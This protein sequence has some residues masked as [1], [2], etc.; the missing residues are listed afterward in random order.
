VAALGR[1]N[2]VSKTGF[3]SKKKG[4]TQE[5]RAGNV[6]APLQKPALSV[7]VATAEEKIRES[8]FAS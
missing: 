8:D 2:V 3:L 4:V 7:P 1:E 6:G 5:V